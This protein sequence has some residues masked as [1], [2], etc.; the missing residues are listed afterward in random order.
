MDDLEEINPRSSPIDKFEEYTTVTPSHHKLVTTARTKTSAPANNAL[1]STNFQVLNPIRW[2]LFY[3]LGYIIGL[4]PPRL[5][6]LN[7]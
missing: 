6:V 3:L 7:H 1:K 4:S 2:S 5:H